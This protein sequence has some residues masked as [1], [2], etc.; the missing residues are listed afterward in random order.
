MEGLSPTTK[1]VNA[2]LSRVLGSFI[3]AHCLRTAIFCAVRTLK[4]TKFKGAR[5]VQRDFGQRGRVFGVLC[6]LVVSQLSVGCGEKD[7]PPV[8]PVKGVVTVKGKPV[9][10]V[11]VSFSL[12]DSLRISSG[13]TNEKGEYV[14]STFNTDDGAIVGDNLV[15]VRQ[16]PKDMQ[17]GGPAQGPEA[18]MKGTGAAEFKSPAKPTGK[19]M[20]G[21]FQIP[22]DV[23]PAK[24]ANVESSGLKRSVVLGDKNEFN[25]DLK[26]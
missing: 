23:V 6:V 1:L 15:T 8:A 14:L 7:R 12:K 9:E 18:M 21:F 26:P 25:F 24:Y 22:S 4:I 3:A 16:I 20:G 19:S 2:N 5:P 17:T 10:G 11:Q 13:I